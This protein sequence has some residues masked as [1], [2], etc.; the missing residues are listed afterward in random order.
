MYCVHAWKR[1]SGAPRTHF[2]ASKISISWGHSPRPLSH[3]PFCGAPPILSAALGMLL[4]LQNQSLQYQ[5]LST[6]ILPSHFVKCFGREEE[7]R[8]S[9][10][11]PT[12]Y[13][14]VLVCASTP[15]TEYAYAMD[16]YPLLTWT[17]RAYIW[18]TGDTITTFYVWVRQ[19]SP[20]AQ[21]SS[22]VLL[23]WHRM[24]AV[25]SSL[26]NSDMHA[27][28]IASEGKIIS[29]HLILI[30]SGLASFP[31]RPPLF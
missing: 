9:H 7:K 14:R 25:T 3:N 5:C 4:G 24:V 11:L 29:K 20:V 6:C 23:L 17:S 22:S 15:V 18:E 30:P 12:L 26:L 19:V 2:R 28:K 1:D 8:W 16:T 21:S 10:V 31:C 27:D 13:T